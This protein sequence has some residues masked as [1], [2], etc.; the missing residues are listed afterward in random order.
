MNLSVPHIDHHTEA[1]LAQRIARAKSRVSRRT[2]WNAFVLAL[3]G[4]DVIMAALAF[5][6]AYFI[7]FELFSSIFNGGVWPTKSFYDYLSLIFLVP[8]WVILYWVVG[9]YNRQ[10]L[11]GGVQEYAL[12]FR[13][14]TMSFLIV[15][16][17]GFL[18]P[19]LIIARGWLLMAWAF[20]FLLTASSRFCLRRV[21]YYL[22]QH[23]FFLSPTVIVGANEEGRW[24][25]NQLRSW[26]TSGLHVVGFVDE[27]VYPGTVLFGNLRALGMV[28]ELDAIISKYQVEELVLAT[29]SI[30]SRNKILDVFQ[31]YGIDSNVNVRMSSGLYEI[32]TTGLTVNEFAYVPLVGVNKIRLTGIDEIFKLCLDYLITL[33]SMII[34]LPLMGILALLVKLDSPGPVL[35][36]RRVMGMNGQQYDALKFRTMHVNGDE[37]LAAYP[38]L[39]VELAR[40]H[41]LKNDPRITR[42]GRFL[43]KYSLD[44]LPQLFNVLRREMSLVG[45]R[46]ISPAEMANYG[47]WGINLLTVRPGITGLWQV[48]GRSDV[49]Y[50][51]RVRLDMH[52]IRNWNIWLDLQL[53]IQTPTV[54][55]KGRGAY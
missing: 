36:W 16:I 32:I 1:N 38:E 19:D 22:R 34:V 2:Q 21:V 52:Y 4:S 3:I 28:E 29:S 18:Q 43:R 42:I 5:Q 9:L 53:L 37:V 27:K 54:V 41:K 40:N 25:A 50:Q 17:A 45:P 35:H 8:L 11:L 12:I 10:N 24:L 39:A 33:P 13:A 51:D 6:L 46:M 26:K 14:T 55:I 23:G 49:S 44:E 48:S 20:T 47:Q 15:I 7:R 30:S 31:R